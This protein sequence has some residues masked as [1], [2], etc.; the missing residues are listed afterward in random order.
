MEI[1]TILAMEIIIT[2]T[3]MATTITATMLV[4][5]LVTLTIT[6][7]L[8]TTRTVLLQLMLFSHLEPDLLSETKLQFPTRAIETKVQLSIITYLLSK[9][10]NQPTLL[11]IKER[12]ALIR[13]VITKTKP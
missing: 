6:N 4:T 13:L 12:M 1:T 9:D 2:V 5:M 11:T 3:M 7:K 10:L 8:E